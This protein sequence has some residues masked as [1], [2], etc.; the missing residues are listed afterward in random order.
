VRYTA[1][2]RASCRAL[3]G[4]NA[5]GADKEYRNSRQG[6]A[7]NIFSGKSQRVVHVILALAIAILLIVLLSRSLSGGAARAQVKDAVAEGGTLATRLCDSCHAVGRSGAST[8]VA[9]DVPSFLSI[10]NKPG[11]SAEAIAGRIVVPH[12]PMPQI[13]L[14]RD[15]IASLSA[16]IM[17]LRR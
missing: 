1:A 10:A 8:T 14:T 7:M 16:Y 13:A 6:A 5:A 4:D 9:A 3:T 12:P 11:Q 17:S 15:E 2:A